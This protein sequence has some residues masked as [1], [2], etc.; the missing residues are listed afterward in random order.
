MAVRDVAHHPIGLVNALGDEC[1][2]V[3][4]YA[5]EVIWLGADVLFVVSRY[6]VQLICLQEGMGR[7]RIDPD[8]GQPAPEP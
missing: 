2:R 8:T 3:S 4:T 5:G 1:F 7:Y 6:T